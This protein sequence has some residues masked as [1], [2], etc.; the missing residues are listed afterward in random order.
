MNGTQFPWG[1]RR[2]YFAVGNKES[3]IF[4]TADM[5]NRF[6]TVGGNTKFRVPSAFVEDVG[7][8]GEMRELM[9]KIINRHQW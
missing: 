1:M 6:S 4:E 5:G 8:V 2:V 7:R 9:L 3:R